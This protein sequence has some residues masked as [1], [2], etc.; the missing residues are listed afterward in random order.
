MG[1]GIEWPTRWGGQLD[2]G[3]RYLL[4]P[5]AYSNMFKKNIYTYIQMNT[6][7]LDLRFCHDLG[8]RSR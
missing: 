5:S 7:A 1:L 2:G 8:N 6:Q 4:L 3:L